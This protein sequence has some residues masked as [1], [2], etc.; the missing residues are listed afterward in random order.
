MQDPDEGWV[1]G[2]IEVQ[3]ISGESEGKGI[4]KNIVSKR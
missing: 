3:S 1:V 4:K 2:L